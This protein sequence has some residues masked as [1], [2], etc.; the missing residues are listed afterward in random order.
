MG[1]WARTVTEWGQRAFLGHAALWHGAGTLQWAE[2]KL[3]SRTSEGM[4][5]VP[6]DE[7][8]SFL[9]SATLSQVTQSF[10]HLK[11]MLLQVSGVR[12]RAEYQSQQV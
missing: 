3:Y 6:L 12:V 9:N 1:L 8:E 7:I 5:Q 2:M 11:Y 4:D 10:S